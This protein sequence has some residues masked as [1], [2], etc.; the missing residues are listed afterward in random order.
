MSDLAS[1]RIKRLYPQFVISTHQQ[2][3]DDTIVVKRE[4]ILKILETL[5]DD[6]ELGFSLPLDITCVDKKDLGETPRFEVVYHL[7]N[8]RNGALIRVKVPLE[9]SDPTLPSSTNLFKGFEWFERET[10]DMFGII[11]TG[12]PDL[13]RILLYPEFIGHPLRKDYPRRGH[14]P[15]VDMPN[16][17]SEGR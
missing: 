12:H 11:F 14:Q 3:G 9:E 17:K 8:I 15:L 5:R 6:P 13:R 7:R 16:L 2:Y 1:E 4:G 10:Y